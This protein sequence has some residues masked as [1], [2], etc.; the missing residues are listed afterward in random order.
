MFSQFYLSRFWARWAYGLGALI[1]G[2][3]FLNSWLN[4]R[5]NDWTGRFYDEL[6]AAIAK[7]GGQASFPALTPMLVE[8]SVLSAL[9]VV[10]S[11]AVN[12]FTRHWAFM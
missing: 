1:I 12:W 11:P 3:W 8:W 9:N 2:L 10:I 7:P 4:V 6:Q 5:L